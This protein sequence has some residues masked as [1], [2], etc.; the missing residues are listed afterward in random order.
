MVPGT[1][2]GIG[3][4]Q[5]QVNDCVGLRAREGAAVAAFL[6]RLTVAN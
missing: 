4:A 3:Q 2:K 6:N 5:D 1:Q